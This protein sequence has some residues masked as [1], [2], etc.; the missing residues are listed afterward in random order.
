MIQTEIIKN[1]FAFA[2][3]VAPFAAIANTAVADT[4]FLERNVSGV[5]RGV[6]S[7]ESLRPALVTVEIYQPTN[8]HSIIVS[9]P[10]DYIASV[11]TNQNPRA[12]A[13]SNLTNEVQYHISNTVRG[14]GGIKEFTTRIIINRVT[15]LITV[16]MHFFR[17][18]GNN[19]QVNYSGSCK[20]INNQ[21]KF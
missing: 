3:I 20:K 10:D 17:L 8:Y 13:I 11:G 4:T 15:G 14:I 12:I 7:E 9:G 16:N 6:S 19:S 21:K 1:L 2:L 18:N 5:W